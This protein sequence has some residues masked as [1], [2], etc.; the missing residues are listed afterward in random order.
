MNKEEK[1][2]LEDFDKS[3]IRVFNERPTKADVQALTEETVKLLRLSLDALYITLGGQLLGTAPPSKVAGIIRYLAAT[4]RFGRKD[5]V[6]NFTAST[7]TP[8]L[9][10][11]VG[12][13]LRRV[14]ARRYAL[15]IKNGRRASRGPK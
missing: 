11:R 14:N 6:W 2:A 15:P 4:V 10:R 12:I 3:E 7:I 8:R 5:I 9:E 1:F 13:D